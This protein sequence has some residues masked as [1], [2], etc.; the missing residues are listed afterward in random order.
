MP[1]LDDGTIHELLDGE[2]SSTDLA[3]ITAHL[4]ECAAC[5]ARL[6]QAQT[7][8][9]EADELI[10]LLDQEPL[11]T[12]GT[13]THHTSATKYRWMRP[14]AWAASLVIAAG[15]G[16]AARDSVRLLPPS[17]AATADRPIAA[18]T[19]LPSPP[20]DAA[21]ARA[22]VTSRRSAPQDK[23]AAK[24]APPAAPERSLAT[25]ESE[26]AVGES[27]ARAESAAPAA[28]SLSAPASKSLADAAPP[29]ADSISLAGAMQLLGGHLRL[30]DG[31]VPRRLE[32][33]GP[34]VRVIY[35]LQR[36][37]L[38]LAQRLLDGQISWRL[39][40][41][42]GFPADSLERHATFRS[43]CAL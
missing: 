10:E 23:P 28:A 3:P 34:E 42:T 17:G 8:L 7:V 33:I 30:L 29:R 18:T 11:V 20:L 9:A 22:A 16:Y 36:G 6:E 26:S 24:A 1:H 14:V 15:A 12:H 40:A 5:R 13:T 4:A 39:L 21:P 25:R 37:E 27:R 35:P 38:V 32:V 2:I 43:G 31:V 19:V 41:P